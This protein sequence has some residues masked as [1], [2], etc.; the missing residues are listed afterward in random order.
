M[1]TEL[2][3]NYLTVSCENSV[4][5]LQIKVFQLFQQIIAPV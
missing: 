3:V 5:T 1:S 4:L 2:S